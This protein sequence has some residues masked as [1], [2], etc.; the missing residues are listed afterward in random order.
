[1]RFVIP[2]SLLV[3]SLAVE[4][5]ALPVFRHA[6][7][8]WSVSDYR[9]EVPAG[10]KSDEL[11]QALL[12]NAFG[13]IRIDRVD[14][15][16]RASLY[17]PYSDTAIWTGSFE[18]ESYR[19]LVDSPARVELVRRILSGHSAVWVV[20]APETE[21]KELIAR[22]GPALTQFEKSS[23]LPAVAPGDLGAGPPL[24]LKF[25]ILEVDPSDAKEAAFLAMISRAPILKGPCV[26]PIFGRGRALGVL[27]PEK[28]NAKAI[29]ETCQFLIGSCSCELDVG[30]D[31][32][33]SVDWGKELQRVG[34]A[35]L[36]SEAPT[37]TSKAAQP[38]TVVITP[39]AISESPESQ[40]A[41]KY[42]PL[43]GL[44]LFALGALALCVG[45]RTGT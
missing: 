42:L 3:T 5:C 29:K 24:L 41:Q 27:Q 33:I 15:L 23:R 16:P 21:R 34:G 17:S 30:W 7:E 22:L 39:K 36:K 14:D 2:I 11:V 4:A 18:T 32:L 8:R 31:L 12:A 35:T 26:V 43:A 10:P 1:M 19:Q 6:L 25:S 38:E 45:R 40:S 44:I 37:P 20:V 13:N 9:L 28:L